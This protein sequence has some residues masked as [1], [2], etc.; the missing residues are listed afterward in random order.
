[1]NTTGKTETRLTSRGFAAVPFITHIGR[2]PRQDVAVAEAAAA[3]TVMLNATAHGWVA[4]GRAHCWFVAPV[5]CR[6]PACEGRVLC[7]HLQTCPLPCPCSYALLQTCSGI[8]LLVNRSKH[9]A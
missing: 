7:Q 4:L 1:M 8:G 6:Q 5:H 9:A 2:Y 3:S